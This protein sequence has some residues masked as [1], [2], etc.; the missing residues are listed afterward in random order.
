[1]LARPRSEGD[2]NTNLTDRSNK[3]VVA[4][5]VLF[6]LVF[7]GLIGAATIILFSIASIS[8]LD[9]GKEPITES[10][11]GDRVLPYTGPNLGP[12]PTEASSAIPDSPK[13]LSAFPPQSASTTETSEVMGA[14]PS[15]ERPSSDGEGSATKPDAPV[16]FPIRQPHTETTRST[17]SSGSEPTAVE[18]L[19]LVE[20]RVIPGG[21]LSAPTLPIP[22]EERDQM[23]R[24]VETYQNQPLKLDQ[25]KLG[26]D[27]KAPIQ[28]V[29]NQR[30]P[31]R[32]VSPNRVLRNRVQK[33]CGSI[34][35]PTLRRHCVASF[36]IQDR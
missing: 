17:D 19:P 10:R 22:A 14:N 30:V 8:L 2:T 4:A 28:K 29:Q 9:T 13:T 15:V 21:S 35:F 1:V 33:E 36:G 5:S 31:R 11:I 18:P 3:P 24:A 26:P 32:P 16:A 27:E 20:A 23:S 12:I 6:P 25:G 34:T 7:M